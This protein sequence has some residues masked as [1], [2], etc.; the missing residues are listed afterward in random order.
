MHNFFYYSLSDNVN[1][2]SIQARIKQYSNNI[3]RSRDFYYS[4]QFYMAAFLM[5]HLHDAMTLMHIYPISVSINRM[6]DS[7]LKRFLCV[8]FMF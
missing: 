3:E 2:H 8:K 6:L 5:V 7:Q 1:C 4:S